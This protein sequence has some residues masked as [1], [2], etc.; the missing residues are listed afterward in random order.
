M[1]S[2][3]ARF[4]QLGALL[5]LPLTLGAK[6][7][8]KNVDLGNDSP[9]SLAGK[10]ATGTGG[11]YSSND[12]GV[13]GSSKSKCNRPGETCCSDECVPCGH[14]C[15]AQFCETLKKK[16]AEDLCIAWGINGKLCAQSDVCEQ[17]D[18]RGL[19]VVSNCPY[20]PVYRPS[21]DR[22]QN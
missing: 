20:S 3:L 22:P 4:I 11:R 15:T 1:G 8:D 18:S 17:R 12:A 16:C 5:L 19:C 10:K 21:D 6:E 7:C 9:A 2:K 13:C 14:L